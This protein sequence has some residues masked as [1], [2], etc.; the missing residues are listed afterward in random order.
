MLEQNKE[1]FASFK[2]IH[3]NFVKNP[4]AY[5]YRF[6]KVGQRVLPVLREHEARLCGKT[7]R[8]VY[9]NFSGNLADKFRS[10]VKAHFSM[11]DFIGVGIS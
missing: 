2:V 10:E 6:N 11:I 7:E 3:D 1:L 8:G 4:D 9:S 5:S